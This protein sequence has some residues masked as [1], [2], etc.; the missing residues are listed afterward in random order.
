MKKR[1]MK[2]QNKLLRSFSAI[3]WRF[4]DRLGINRSDRLCNEKLILMP[5]IWHLTVDFLGERC[6]MLVSSHLLLPIDVTRPRGFSLENPLTL[7]EI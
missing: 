2:H 3:D 7:N 1:K 6:T 4:N 5:S